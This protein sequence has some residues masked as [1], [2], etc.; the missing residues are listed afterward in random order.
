MTL[1]RELPQ[2]ILPVINLGWHDNEQL[3]ILSFNFIS[4]LLLLQKWLA[5]KI[6]FFFCPDVWNRCT[7][8][9]LCLGCFLVSA[10]PKPLCSQQHPTRY[11]CSHP[12]R[13]YGTSLY[14]YSLLHIENARERSIFR[15]HC[16]SKQ[17]KNIASTALWY[18]VLRNNITPGLYC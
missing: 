4:H 12:S 8:Y 2:L 18:N 3:A 6:H 10:I 15:T 14:Y 11:N 1:R 5:S 17:L 7:I 13:R 9:C 16:Q